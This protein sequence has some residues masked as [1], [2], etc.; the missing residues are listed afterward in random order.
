MGIPILSSSDPIEAKGHP[1]ATSDDCDQW[2]YMPKTP[3]EQFNE[4]IE[5]YGLNYCLSISPSNAQVHLKCTHNLLTREG[6]CAHGGLTEPNSISDLV[7]DTDLMD[8]RGDDV[9]TY[10]PVMTFWASLSP[11]D[12]HVLAHIEAQNPSVGCFSQRLSA[13]F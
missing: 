9:D 4:T 11:N 6:I 7:P 2:S 13:G 8:P 10:A 3:N 5:K 12:F 1:S